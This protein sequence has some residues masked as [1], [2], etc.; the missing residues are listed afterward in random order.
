MNQLNRGFA[1]ECV[2]IENL[3][4]A[5]RY[6]ELSQSN[7]VVGV[8]RPVTAVGGSEIDETE[9]VVSLLEPAT[10]VDDDCL[11]PFLGGL[12]SMEPND[13]VGYLLVRASS[14]RAVASSPA[15]AERTRA[16]SA[17]SPSGKYASLGQGL[18]NHGPRDMTP[19][20]DL[21][22]TDHVEIDWNSQIAERATKAYELSA[23]I[24]DRRLSLDYEDVQVA[25]GLGLI[26][27]AR[28]EDDHV[29]TGCSRP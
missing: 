23:L 2:C 22:G 26:L 17:E 18:V 19:L 25:R 14:C 4:V 20:L 15:L 5:E 7:Q 29:S 11:E 10:P 21:A 13:A 8:R 9:D 27:G 1:I 28:T 16:S 24:G 3:V 12:L 6:G